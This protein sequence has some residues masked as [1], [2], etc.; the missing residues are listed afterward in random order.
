[1]GPSGTWQFALTNATAWDFSVLTGHEFDGDELDVSGRGESGVHV[2]GY[3]C[4]GGAAVLSVAVAV[5]ARGAE[6]SIFN[7]QEI[8]HGWTLMDTDWPGGSVASLA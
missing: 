8:N 1:M 3:E 4:G 5:N 7:I 2:C 6:T